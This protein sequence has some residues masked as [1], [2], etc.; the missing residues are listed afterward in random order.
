MKFYIF[1][2]KWIQTVWS[3]TKQP[4]FNS[5]TLFFKLNLTLHS[6]NPANYHSC[7]YL[8]KICYYCCN[9]ITQTLCHTILNVQHKNF[10]EPSSNSLR[11]SA[12][13]RRYLPS[14]QIFF[15]C[16]SQTKL[17]CHYDSQRELFSE[18]RKLHDNR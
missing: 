17:M 2:I 13:N 12:L 9:Q 15:K 10:S 7:M 14:Q 16:L 1:H 5:C 6:W 4:H 8:V 3:Y 11:H 18:Q